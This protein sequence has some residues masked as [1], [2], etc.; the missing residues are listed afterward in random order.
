M[1]YQTCR[2]CRHFNNGVCGMHPMYT[3]SS[4]N[5]D[6][7][8]SIE[9]GELSAIMGELGP[10]AVERVIGRLVPDLPKKWQKAI[11]DALEDC[12]ES[13]LWEISAVAEAWAQNIH[14]TGAQ[15]YIEDPEEFSCVYFK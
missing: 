12:D 6:I 11:H 8:H 7:Q 1:N 13:A 10:H 14:D 5:M 15:T 2:W 4:T 3:E 9:E